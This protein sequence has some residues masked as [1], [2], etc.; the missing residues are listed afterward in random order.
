MP[1]APGTRLGAYDVISH[2][3]EGGMGQVYRARDT[4]LGRDIALKL[5]PDSFVHDADRIARFRR[6]AQVLAGLNHPHIGALY[7][8]DEAEAGQFLV[9]ELVDGRTL[10]ERLASGPVPLDEALAI[11]LQVAGGLEAAHEKGIVHRDL[12]PANI[13]LTAGGQ[14]KIL[15]FGLAKAV[16]ASGSSDVGVSPT[17]T[18]GMTQ[19]GTVLGT[20]PYMS[21]E[22]ARGKHVDKRTDVWAFGC[23]LFE[24]LAGRQPFEGDTITD[25][26]SAIV[27]AEPDWTRLPADT[28]EGVHRLIRRCLQKD[29]ARRLRDIGDAAF[30]LDTDSTNAAPVTA[31]AATRRPGRGVWLLVTATALLAAAASAALTSYLR[32]TPPAAVEKFHLMIDE[33]EGTSREPVISADGRKVVYAGRTRLWVRSLGEWKAREL[34]GTESAVRPFWSPDGNWIGYFRSEE[35]LKVPADGGP[36]MRVATLPAVHAPLGAASAVWGEDGY[37]VIAQAASGALLRVPAGGGEARAFGDIPQ[38]QAIDLHDLRPLPGGGILAA[39]HR[40]SGVDAIGIFKDNALRIVH[41]ATAVQRPAYSAPGYLVFERR[42][43]NAGL[44]ALPFSLPRLE[45]TGEAFLIGEGS[46]P[47]TSLAGTLAFVEGPAQVARRL[48]WFSLTGEAGETLADPRE[49]NE[50]VAISRDGRQ[51]LA[52]AADGIWAYDTGTRARRRI[53]TNPSD[54]MPR[55]VTSDTI[56]F[57]RTENNLPTVVLKRLGG[58]GEERVLARRARFP[59][60]TASGRRIVFNI[61]QEGGR[62]WEVAWT[63]LDTEGSLMRLPA[64]HQG[65][66]FPAVSPDGTL[67]AYVSGEIGRDEVFVTTLPDGNGKWQASSDGGGWA[68]FHPNGKDLIYRSL[69]GALMLVPVS[70]GTEV[71]VGAPRKLFDWGAG[72][73]PYYDIA[74]DGSRGLAAMPLVRSMRLPRLSIVQNWHLEFAPR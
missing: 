70:G 30:E 48:A 40:A 8:I 6:E 53:T 42:P 14:V 44:W 39:V 26:V 43:P 54:I 64:M 69:D 62:G 13:A 32:P 35:L 47:T 72:W 33:D 38:D 68:S 74:D 60:A 3:G 28:P 37:I 11:A 57:V 58:G 63:D 50:G 31:A 36:V 9:L 1:L 56:V 5:L 34:A 2:L 17:L 12:K 22:Q 25:I 73:A 45:V 46:E 67:V 16:D 18:A 65:A 27:R 41:T 24:M 29:P 51:A 23:V 61:E 55:W 49:W 10:A 20:A 66:R 7:G 71:S 4:R 21:P 59:R 52:A 15:D 19:A